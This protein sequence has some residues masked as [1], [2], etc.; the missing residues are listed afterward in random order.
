MASSTAIAR[1]EIWSH[2]MVTSV[3]RYINAIAAPALMSA[4]KNEITKTIRRNF[5]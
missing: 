2:L 1:Q 3:A 5:P 4:I